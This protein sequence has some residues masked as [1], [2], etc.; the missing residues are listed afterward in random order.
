MRATSQ[1]YIEE[2]TAPWESAADEAY[3]HKSLK[4][5]DITAEAEHQGWQIN[6]LCVYVGCRGFV[7]TSTASLLE[8]MGVQGQAFGQVVESLSEAAE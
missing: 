1:K 7:A 2:L 8:T 4:Y 6:M 3:E 5:G